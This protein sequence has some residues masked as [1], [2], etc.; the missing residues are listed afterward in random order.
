M[1]LK[2]NLPVGVALFA[3]LALAGLMGL[4]ALTVMPSAEAQDGST[5]IEY[6]ENGK[7]PV[8]TFTA[9]DPEGATPII[10]SMC[11]CGRHFGQ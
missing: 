8:A 10:W 9:T 5:T 11:G 6:A 7:D 2:V 1:K 3:A 4:F